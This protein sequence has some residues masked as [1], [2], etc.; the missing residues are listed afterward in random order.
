MYTG[1]F[2]GDE[3]HFK[4]LALAGISNVDDAL[5]FHVLNPVLDRR[6]VRAIIPL[7]TH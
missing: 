2:G 6:Q 4:V 3:N 7:A 5:T 1:L